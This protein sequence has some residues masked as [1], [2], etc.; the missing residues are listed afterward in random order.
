M[1]SK[2][3]SDQLLFDPEIERTARRL[4]S[5]ARRRANIAKA[6]NNTTAASSQQLET[7]DESQEG[8]FFHELFE[9]EEI[10]VTEQPI[11]VIMAAPGPCANSPRLNPQFAR[12]AANGRT[13]E[14]KTGII[15]LICASSFAGL[16]HEDPYTHLTRF[17]ELA[18]TTGVAQAD[19]KALFKR[20]FPHS[21]LSKAKDWYLDQPEIVMTNWNTLEENF[22]K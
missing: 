1:R 9:E 5:K 18:C 13:S 11:V 16:D 12:T 3:S 20:L 7:I 17:Y 19:E 8:F 2:V 6:R 22:W 4:N 10:E 15:Q 21:L 14:L